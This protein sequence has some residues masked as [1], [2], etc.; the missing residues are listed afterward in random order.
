MREQ[1]S[2]RR[3]DLHYMALQM[4]FWAMFGSICA[5]QAALLL[6][7]GFSN[8]QVGLIIAVRCL[9]GIF[10]QPLLGMFSDR[11]PDV[12]LKVLLA[13]SLALS[14]VVGLAL[15]FLPLGLWGT[16]A[17]FAVIGA[18]EVSAYPLLDAMAI[19]FINDGIP[20]HYSLGRGVGS[21]AYAV[22]CALLG[23][24]SARRGVE[25][26]LW[27]HASLVLVELV[28]V[29]AYPSHRPKPKPAGAKAEDKPQSPLS[30]LRS[31]PRFSLTL[32]ASLF[33][34]LGVISLSNFLVNVTVAKGG[35]QTELGYG[36]FLM[37]AFELPAA[38]LFPHLK[39]RLGTS[40]LM[41][42]S[43]LF[44]AAKC[45]A[46]LL[47]PNVGWLLS[48]QAL[49][50]LG[51]G[52]FTPDSVFLVNENVPPADR[53]QGQTLM[54]VASN[55]LGGVLGSFFAG[56]ALDSGGV[57]AMLLL[58]LGACLLAALLAF[59]AQRLPI[60]RPSM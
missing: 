15:L 31:H 19:Q 8:S 5:Y 21:F 34:I 35:G 38:L 26:V 52:L 6:G 57:N 3:L 25:S 9:T 46:F 18:F 7:R 45:L 43:M 14:F 42:F 53:V 17:V 32:L 36:L 50:M 37:G 39:R 41:T 40:G 11:R 23:L 51:Y 60:Q 27:V 48:V 59:L 33:G 10:S 29:A 4:G 2:F 56:R 20:I 28:L 30:L 22:C 55:G 13:L 24:L 44:C 54:M 47:A 49:Q 16:I 12:P 1:P 58:C